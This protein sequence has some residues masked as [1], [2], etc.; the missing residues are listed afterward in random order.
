MSYARIIGCGSYIPE[1]VL[2]NADLEKLIETSDEWILKRVGVR[3]RHIVGDSP[4]NTTA[5][6]VKAAKNALEMAGI[7]AQAID[8]IIVG[9]A[10]PQYYFPSTAC[11]VQQQLNIRTDIPAFDVNAACAG[12]IYALSIAD[13]FIRGG[14]VKTALVIGAE[15]LTKLVDW[16]D[17]STCILFG[18][19]AGAVILQADKEPG[20]LNTTLHANGHYG[21]LITA[22]NPV[23]QPRLTPPYLKMRGN[24]VFKVAVTKLGEIVEEV[25][26]KSGLQKTDI[27]WLIP[28]QANMRIITATAKRLNL[29]L[30][31]VILT[32]EHHGNTSAASVPLALDYGVRA[33]KIKKGDTLLLEALG[34]GLVWGAALVKY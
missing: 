33:G 8:L 26:A 1:Q 19:G 28:H 12:F 13:Q 7:D 24:E 6:A 14:T 2:T 10:T 15:A 18:D 25:V 22:D 21:E 17:R 30:E 11:L 9:T 4:D 27:D 16:Q 32:I 34:A 29:P 5:M 23:W 31:R 20:I 3:E